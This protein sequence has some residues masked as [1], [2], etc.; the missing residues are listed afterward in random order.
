MGPDPSGPIFLCASDWDDDGVVENSYVQ[1]PRLVV[2]WSSLK[3]IDMH[4]FGS[5]VRIFRSALNNVT[6]KYKRP[7]TF[8]EFLDLER[9]KSK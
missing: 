1:C 9:K 7:I 3:E 5:R 4:N 8:F 6:Y 2:E